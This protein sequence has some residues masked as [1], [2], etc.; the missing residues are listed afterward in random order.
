MVSR[1]LDWS[2][3]FRRLRWCAEHRGPRQFGTYRND[4][5]V[6]LRLDLRGL[7]SQNGTLAVWSGSIHLDV[8]VL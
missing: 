6:L 8:S 7:V 4:G 3:S 2:G 1:W 5:T